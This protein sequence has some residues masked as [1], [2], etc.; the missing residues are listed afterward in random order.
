MATNTWWLGVIGGMGTR[1]LIGAGRRKREQLASI[2]QLIETN[3]HVLRRL[4]N[5]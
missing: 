1:F 5:S 2:K 4:P 3:D